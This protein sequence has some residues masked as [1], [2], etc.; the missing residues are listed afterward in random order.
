MRQSLLMIAVLAVLALVACNTQYLG[1]TC[2]R[3]NEVCD[4]TLFCRDDFPGG[5]CTQ[6]C[7]PK[8][9]G[10]GCPTDSLCITEDGKQI[11]SP[12]CLRDTDCRSQEGYECRG[13]SGLSVRACRVKPPTDG[14]VP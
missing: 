12:V 14:G 7:S 3:S 4:S 10:A 1:E 11:C 2:D 13:E 9:A 8:G 6:A 5:F